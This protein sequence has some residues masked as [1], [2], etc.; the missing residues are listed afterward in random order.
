MSPHEL[1]NKRTTRRVKVSS[2]ADIRI[3]TDQDKQNR[4][5][6]ITKTSSTGDGIERKEENTPTKLMKGHIMLMLN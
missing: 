2:G 3:G 1:N 6:K 5:E 4:N